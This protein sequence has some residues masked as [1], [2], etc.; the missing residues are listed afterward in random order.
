MRNRKGGTKSLRVFRRYWVFS[1]SVWEQFAL[2]QVRSALVG[3]LVGSFVGLAMAAT[4]SAHTARKS[5][6]RVSNGDQPY[7]VEQ[8]AEGLNFPSS[9]AW[10]PNGAMLITER[11]GGL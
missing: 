5:A 1:A 3:C 4:S 10:L 11:L 7:W 9:M 8:V 2:A 6:A